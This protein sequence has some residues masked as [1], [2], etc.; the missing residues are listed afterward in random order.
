MNFRRVGLIAWISTTPI[1]FPVY[2]FTLGAFVIGCFPSLRTVQVL[3]GAF[4]SIL[5]TL[6]A[7]KIESEGSSW[8]G[9]WGM[10]LRFCALSYL[11]LFVGIPML[12]GGPH[13]GL[14]GEICVVGALALNI[15]N[16]A[17]L[18]F[19]RSRLRPKIR[20]ATVTDIYRRPWPCGLRSNAKCFKSHMYEMTTR[21][22]T[23]K[24]R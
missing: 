23:G 3:A 20:S 9:W 16:G 22:L 17:L 1:L 13:T 19:K 5:V 4:F 7:M 24:L 15:P 21:S 10:H 18:F 11:L 6:L 8:W 2:I 12:Q 14:V